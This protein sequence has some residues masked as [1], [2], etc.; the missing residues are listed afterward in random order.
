MMGIKDSQLQ[1][2]FHQKMP[3]ANLSKN[4]ATLYFVI[5]FN[6]YFKHCSIAMGCMKQTKLTSAN[7]SKKTLCKGKWVIYV[8]I[9][10]KQQDLVSHD[11]HYSMT[12]FE[13]QQH[14]GAQK[15]KKVVLFNFLKK[16]FFQGKGQFGL[17]L[18]QN[19]SILYP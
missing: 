12:D 13:T 4:Y 10:T 16:S 7:F 15:I 17:N 9:G 11:L 2:I 1:L 18:A 3:Q 8:E 19:Y 5:H 14:I 6:D